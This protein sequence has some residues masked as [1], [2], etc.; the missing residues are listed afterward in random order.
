MSASITPYYHLFGT[1]WNIAKSV[2]IVSV[3]TA[4]CNIIYREKGV[5]YRSILGSTEKSAASVLLKRSSMVIKMSHHARQ[6]FYA[7]VLS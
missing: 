7:S 3:K 4:F 2:T 5:S 1:L 6:V